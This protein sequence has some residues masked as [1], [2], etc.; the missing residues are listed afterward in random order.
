MDSKYKLLVTS[1]RN[2]FRI[3]RDEDPKTFDIYIEELGNLRK[4]LSQTTD[5]SFK[6]RDLYETERRMNETDEPEDD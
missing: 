5:L 6:I 2:Y 1:I 4:F 3:H